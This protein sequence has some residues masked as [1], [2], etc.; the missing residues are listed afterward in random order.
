MSEKKADPKPPP[1]R[2][3]YSLIRSFYS[4]R[5]EAEM[6]AILTEADDDDVEEEAAEPAPEKPT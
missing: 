3:D 2:P 4:S 5:S 1:F 6:W